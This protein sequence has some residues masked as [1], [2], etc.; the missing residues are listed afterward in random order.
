MF[1]YLNFLVSMRFLKKSLKIY[2]LLGFGDRI[3]K[4]DW[5][6]AKIGP[7]MFTSTIFEIHFWAVLPCLSQI[8]LSWPKMAETQQQ[9]KC[10]KPTK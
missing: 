4:F 3:T 2:R 9:G 5:N 10:Q 6:V 1:V 8:F 7:K